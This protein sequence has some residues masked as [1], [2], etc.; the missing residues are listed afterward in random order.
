M[1]SSED[2]EFTPS[3]V[4]PAALGGWGGLQ[5]LLEDEYHEW[6]ARPAPALPG[7][8]PPVSVVVTTRGY[9]ARLERC[10]RSTLASRYADLEVI[11]VDNRSA[12][13]AMRALLAER[14]AD[15]PRVRCVEDPRSGVAF[16]RNAG[17][18]AAGGEFVAF[19][20]DNS[21]VYPDWVARSVEAFDRDEDIACVLGLVLPSRLRP[22][23]RTFRQND[24]EHPLLAYTHGL[25]G[26]GAG[27]VVHVG[28]AR[29]L[30]GFDTDLGAGTPAAGG[31]DLDLFVRLLREGHAIAYEPRAIARHE[32]PDGSAPLR[33]RVFLEGVGVGALLVKQLLRGP[34]RRDVLRAVRVSGNEGGDERRPTRIRC[35][36]MLLGPAAYLASVATRPLRAT[37]T[38]GTGRAP[39]EFGHAALPEGD[40]VKVVSFLDGEAPPPAPAARSAIQSRLIRALRTAAAFTC[41]AAPLAIALG[42]PSTLRMAAVLAF[43]CIGAGM[44]LMTGPRGR[45]EPGLALGVG[46]AATPVFALGTF[47]FGWWEP[48]VLLL[49]LVAPAL[50]YLCPSSL[51]PCRLPASSCRSSRSGRARA[52]D[53][54]ARPGLHSRPRYTLRDFD[55]RGPR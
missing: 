27:M 23:A 30:G 37:R 13:G 50:A 18:A 5:S 19:T 15:K 8:P 53:R 40:M 28:T 35:V 31:E 29:R 55:H 12:D 36:G 54:Q 43:V 24:D 39:M 52:G 47:G 21:E 42:L 38:I 25:I 17:L 22:D 44:V 33:R 10:L 1:K 51:W 11:V 32:H 16:A 2:H 45:P 6:S 34:G 14:F 48:Q 26:S 46:L 7:P 41:L 4:G 9:S 49:A 20:D 3:P